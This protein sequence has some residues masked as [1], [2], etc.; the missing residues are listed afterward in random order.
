MLISARAAEHEM[1]VAV[2]Q[3]GRDP[4]AAER[5]DVLRPKAG[6]LGALSDAD[7]LA[8]LNSDRAI[9]DQPERVARF[10]FKGR[11]IAVD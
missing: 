6:E 8:V 3:A 1:G 9:L 2:D 11:D 5:V 10:L 7:D 4:G